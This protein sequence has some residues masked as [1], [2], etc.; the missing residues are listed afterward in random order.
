MIIHVHNNNCDNH[1]ISDD[2]YCDDIGDNKDVAGPPV[3]CHGSV[4]INHED[5]DGH[6]DNN[7]IHDIDYDHD[8]NNDDHNV[9]YSHDKSK[10][11]SMI[12][13]I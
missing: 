13:V 6:H 12:T 4:V 7:D 3:P 9:D 5:D 10:I 2:H 8:D 1:D 11:V